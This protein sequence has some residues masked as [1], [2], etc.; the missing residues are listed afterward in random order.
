MPA[1]LHAYMP[2]CLHAYMPTCLHAYMPTC[3]HAY[4]PT[5]LHAYMPTC[6]WQAWQAWVFASSGEAEL[7]EL[8]REGVA[9]QSSRFNKAVYGFG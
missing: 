1:C 6:P 7:L 5:C 9:P 8:L 4:M 2:T 3:L